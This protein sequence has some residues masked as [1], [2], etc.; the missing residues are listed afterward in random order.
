MFILNDV[1]FYCAK[2][3]LY[4]SLVQVKALA[5]Q[6]MKRCG[7]PFFFRSELAVW[8][9][10]SVN[11]LDALLKRALAAGEIIRIRRGLY[12]LAQPYQREAPNPL[13]LAQHVYGPSYIGLESALSFHGLIPEAVYSVVSVSLNRSRVFDTPLGRFDFVRVPQA[14]FFAGIERRELPGGNGAVLVSSPLKALADLVYVR[15]SNEPPDTLLGSLRV[16]GRLKE[17]VSSASIDELAGNYSSRR[18]KH[19]LQQVRKEVAS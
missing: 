16:E 17:L 18:V 5:E 1:E 14:C 19:F 9:D 13:A 12:M 4:D 6:V 7:R 10:G 3:S 11:R 15:R 2:L 8:V